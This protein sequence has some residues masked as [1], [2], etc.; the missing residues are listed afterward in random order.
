MDTPLLN[1]LDYRYLTKPLHLLQ[2]DAQRLGTDGTFINNFLNAAPQ[3]VMA[4]LDSLPFTGSMALDVSLLLAALYPVCIVIYRL[5]FSPLSKIPGPWLTR[6]SSVPEVQALKRQQRTQWVNQLF[7][8]NP[9]AVAVRTGPNSVSFNH[10]DAIK[11]IYGALQFHLMREAQ[12]SYG[13]LGHPRL[14]K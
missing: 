14:L 3:D 13:T 2:D 11:A 5:F 4:A 9:G 7:A 1:A 12:N 8:Q 6:I 10:P